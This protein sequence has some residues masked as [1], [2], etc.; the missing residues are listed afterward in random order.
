MGGARTADPTFDKDSGELARGS[1]LPRI[2]GVVLLRLPMPSPDE[3]GRRL[4]E[5]ITMREDPVTFQ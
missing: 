3:V 5:Q 2:C 4:A 1:A